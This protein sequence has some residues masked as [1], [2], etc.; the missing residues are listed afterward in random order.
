MNDKYN[1]GYENNA[2]NNKD[3]DEYSK[4]YNEQLKEFS[5][6]DGQNFDDELDLTD[7]E[8]H[9]ESQ[10]IGTPQR[11]DR[12]YPNNGSSAN[13]NG[14]RTPTYSQ[15]TG[16][17]YSYNKNSANS[18]RNRAADNYQ[19]KSAQNHRPQNS[20]SQNRRANS[21]GNVQRRNPKANQK[22]T[23]SRERNLQFGNS[24]TDGMGRKPHNVYDS[25]NNNKNRSKNKKMNEKKKSPVK[26]FFKWLIIILLILLILA[27]LLVYRY[28]SLVNVVDTGKR[29]YTNASMHDDNIMNVLVIGSDSRSIDER[30]RTD[31]MILLSIDKKKDKMTMTSFM[32]D[33]YVEIPNNGWNKLNAANVYGGPEL[34]MDTIE[35]NF[36]VRVDKYVYIDFYSFVDIV[37]AVG[38]IEIEISDEEAEGMEA[39]MAEQNNIMNK[40]K[41]TDYL[42]KGGK[43][44]LNGNQALAYARLRYVGNA[45]FERTQRQRT[46][47]NKIK[48]KAV[49]FNPVKLD[50][51][52]KASLS[53]VTTNMSKMEMQILANRLPFIMKYDTKELRVPDEDMYSYGSHDGQSTLDVDFDACKQLLNQ[54]IYG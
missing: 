37:D 24:R 28:V 31:S 47:M 15:R 40:P 25:K 13:P 1:H 17:S 48:E 3:V 44:T 41:G 7:L 52:A 38:G 18:N 9:D 54:N 42:S 14:S 10:D 36:D 34:L 20:K 35:L 43:L 4:M 2:G 16:N 33:M 23:P 11:T 39:P 19:K 53:H 5:K 26:R 8:F 30:G 46:V 32:R 27:E 50:K 21:S 45:D 6:M 29:L 22:D 12:Y 49:T 51:F